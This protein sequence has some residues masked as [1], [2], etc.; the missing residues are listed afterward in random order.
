MRSQCRQLHHQ[1]PRLP[2]IRASPCSCSSLTVRRRRHTGHLVSQTLGIGWRTGIGKGIEPK[3]LRPRRSW[4]L[5][6]PLPQ[7]SATA[8]RVDRIPYPHP[9]Y[10][11]F[12]DFVT[13]PL[14][15]HTVDAS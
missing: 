2:Y 7:A 12:D 9:S 6:A 11:R 3:Y 8:V 5:L 14:A 10:F 15:L 4:I 1:T 13:A